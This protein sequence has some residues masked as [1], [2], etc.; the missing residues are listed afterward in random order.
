[1]CVGDDYNDYDDIDS[2]EGNVVVG[3]GDGDD[4]DNDDLAGSNRSLTLYRPLSLWNFSG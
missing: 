3:G 4:D 1:L 2:D